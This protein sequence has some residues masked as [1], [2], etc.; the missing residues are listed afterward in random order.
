MP[1]PKPLNTPCR[2]RLPLAPSPCATVVRSA[3]G[4]SYN[5]ILPSP[6]RY[7]NQT[8]RPSSGETSTVESH[9]LLHLLPADGRE[10]KTG[11]LHVHVDQALLPRWERG[12]GPR[13]YD[14]P[15][16]QALTQLERSTTLG[17]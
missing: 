4:S 1:V 14:G 12:V 7:A 6:L 17:Q 15:V 11:L 13:A 3:L 5:T 2:I 16:L 10:K 9:C 8:L